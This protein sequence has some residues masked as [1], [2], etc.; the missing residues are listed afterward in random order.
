MSA[1]ILKSSS[2]TLPMP[3]FL[4]TLATSFSLKSAGLPVT[5]RT[6]SPCSWNFSGEIFSELIPYAA[7][8]YLTAVDAEAEAD[9]FFPR[10]PV[11]FELAGVEDFP[12]FKVRHYVKL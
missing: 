8:I 12:A 5:F 6:A 2:P 11:E 10:I 7:E 4:S 1:G 9:V 3:K